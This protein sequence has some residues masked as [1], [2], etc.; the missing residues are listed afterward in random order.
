MTKPEDLARMLETF[1][2]SLIPHPI[3]PSDT[4]DRVRPATG[5]PK[6]LDLPPLPS[7]P[8]KS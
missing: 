7:C 4:F 5:R 6:P 3:N 8:W 2:R 1:L